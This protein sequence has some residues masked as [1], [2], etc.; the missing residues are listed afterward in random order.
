MHR[1]GKRRPFLVWVLLLIYALISLAGWVRM[2]YAITAW[3]WLDYVGIWPGPWYQL[4]TG[5]LWG[6]AGLVALAW[7]ITE[8]PQAW[9]VGLG[10]A[11]LFA[12][13]YWADR[14]LV[15]GLAT[16]GDNLLF[17]GLLTLLGLLF[18]LFVLLAYYRRKEHEQSGT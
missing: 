18:A 13:T 17:A 2:I 4:I 3:N 14:G 12:I 11:L 15:S 9:Q 5:G 8:R 6:A 10:A 16:G 1:L 7:L